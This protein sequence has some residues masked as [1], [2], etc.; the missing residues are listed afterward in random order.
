MSECVI[1]SFDFYVININ[2]GFPVTKLIILNTPKQ[3][4][5]RQL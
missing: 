5:K 1:L 3:A 2:R 4:N